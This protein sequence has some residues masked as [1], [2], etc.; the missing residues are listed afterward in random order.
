M[1]LAKQ[2]DK[3]TDQTNAL[4]EVEREIE[5]IKQAVKLGK[6]TESLLE[7]LEDAERRRKILT[8]ARPPAAKTRRRG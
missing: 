5:H 1:A 7:M 8:A 6:A 2:E 3:P 4:R